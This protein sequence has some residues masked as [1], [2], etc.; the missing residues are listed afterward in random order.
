MPVWI[1][2]DLHRHER[3]IGRLL[4]LA[5]NALADRLPSMGWGCLEGVFSPFSLSE[6]R[7]S[8]GPR[9][10]REM[11]LDAGRVAKALLKRQVVASCPAGA[12]G[13][14]VS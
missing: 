7:V 8:V 9:V 11:D 5:K 1:A 10:R 6:A 14:L 13:S 12:A 3:P 4:K 2:L